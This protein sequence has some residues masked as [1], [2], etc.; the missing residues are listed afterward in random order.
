M[1]QLPQYIMT[2]DAVSYPDCMSQYVLGY[3]LGH[4][5]HLVE[6]YHNQQIKLW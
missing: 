4:E 2:R 1:C 5:R 6:H 3:I